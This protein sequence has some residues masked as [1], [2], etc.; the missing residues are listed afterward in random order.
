LVPVLLRLWF[1]ILCVLLGAFVPSRAGARGSETR[2]WVF[3][4]T[5]TETRLESEPQAAG[6]HQENGLCHYEHAPGCC[7]AAENRMTTVLGSLD[8]VAK[9]KGKPGYNVLDVPDAIYKKMTPAEFDRLNADWLNAALRRG[10]RIMS[11]TDPA[12]HAQ[13][14]ERIRPG[15]SSQSRYLNLE[16]PMLEEFGAIVPKQMSYPPVTPFIVNP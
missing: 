16:L 12:A 3:A 14:L 10:D 2:T 13:F 4:P 5:T 1:L 7:L 6:T 9:F 8:D 11:V 15:L